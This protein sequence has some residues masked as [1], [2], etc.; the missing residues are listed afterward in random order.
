MVILT[1]SQSGVNN[2]VKTMVIPLSSFTT[3]LLA[4]AFG[5]FSFWG[6]IQFFSFPQD[7]V[8]EKTF[9][10]DPTLV[11]TFWG[12]GHTVFSY[13]LACYPI[14]KSP[15]WCHDVIWMWTTAPS[16]H[17][18]LQRSVYCTYGICGWIKIKIKHLS[19]FLGISSLLP[20]LSNRW[21]S[22]VTTGFLQGTC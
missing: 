21:C 10:N 1:T 9:A 17:C 15:W 6:R 7:L 3:V 16:P 18:V 22:L 8:K 19:T 14:G 12:H 4:E 2:I 13:T 5:G 20:K 11:W